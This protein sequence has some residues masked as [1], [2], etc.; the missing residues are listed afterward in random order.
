MMKRIVSLTL[1]VLLIAALFAGCGSSLE[2]TYKLK[3][4]NDKPVKEFIENLAS[5]TGV[6]MEDALENFG[7]KS[8]E[9]LEN[10]MTITLKSDNTLEYKTTMEGD[11]DSGTGTWKQ[12]GEKITMTIDGE[13]QE[14]TL[15]DGMLEWNLA[16][17]MKITLGK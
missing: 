7:V 11:D 13:E 12:D 14:F 6:S 5:T 16:G 4:I 10:A 1:A 15:K 2:G 8:V 9:E 17:L 3:M